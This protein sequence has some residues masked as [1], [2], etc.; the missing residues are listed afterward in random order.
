MGKRRKS[1]DRERKKT[2]SREKLLKISKSK[3]KRVKHHLMHRTVLIKNTITHLKHTEVEHEVLNHYSNDKNTK[4]N[5]YD[6]VHSYH[7][8]D[9]TPS[10]DMLAD[11]SQQE[12]MFFSL[13]S[14]MTLQA[15]DNVE[16]MFFSLDSNMTL[17]APDNVEDMFFSLDSNMT[18]Q[19][20]DNVEDMFQYIDFTRPEHI[21]SAIASCLC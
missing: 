18:L 10:K 13:D 4:C 15:P 11:F 6:I 17:Q 19:A 7:P 16:D 3:L 21:F 1:E 5:T 8:F 12:Q 9:T 14:S 20:P 2:V